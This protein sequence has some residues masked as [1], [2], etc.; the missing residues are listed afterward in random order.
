MV[1]QAFSRSKIVRIIG[2]PD[3]LD[4]EKSQF[5]A[6]I[7]EL[8]RYGTIEKCLYKYKNQSGQMLCFFA[9]M[10]EANNFYQ[11]L[12]TNPVIDS[13]NCDGIQVFKSKSQNF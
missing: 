1:G 4:T 6:I 7:H 12:K 13:A 3:A 8:H 2:L 10:K 5:N 11:A 9:T